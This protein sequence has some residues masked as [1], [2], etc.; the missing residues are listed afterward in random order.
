MICLW[1]ETL[2]A[3]MLFEHASYGASGY[4]PGNFRFFL[5]NG[6][7]PYVKEK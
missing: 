4:N 7:H 6:I 3:D 1:T 5:Q 2:V